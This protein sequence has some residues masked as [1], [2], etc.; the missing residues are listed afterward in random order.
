MSIP[1]GYLNQARKLNMNMA[2]TDLV[3]KFPGGQA[4]YRIN[5]AINSR[6]NPTD[7]FFVMRETAITYSVKQIVSQRSTPLSETTYVLKRGTSV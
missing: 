3:G 2:S 5:S 1:P 7:F 6:L 4:T